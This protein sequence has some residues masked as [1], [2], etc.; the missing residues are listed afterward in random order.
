MKKQ[1][2]DLLVT[3]PESLYLLLTAPSSR[4]LLRGVRT[5]IVDEVH[6]LARDKRGSHLSLSLE[7]LDA[8]VTES[9]GRVQRIG[10]S[11][12]QR[13]LELVARLLTRRP[14]RAP[15][16]HDRRLRP[17]PRS[18]RGDRAALD[19]ARG[20][21]ERRSDVRHPRP[22]RRAHPA[23]PHDADL[24]QHPEDGRAGRPPVDRAPRRRRTAGAG[25]ATSTPRCSW[26]RTTAAFRRPAGASSRP[27]CA[28]VT[29]A[30]SSP[31][32]RSNWASTSARSSWSARSGRPGPSAPSSSASAGP[33]TTARARRPAGST[34]RPATSWSSAPRCWPP[35]ARGGSTCSS[36]RWPRS[37]CSPSR[38]W[39]RWPPPTSATSRPS[40]TSSAGPRRTPS[41]HGRTSTTW[42]PWPAGASRPAG[43]GAVPTCTTTPSTAACGPAGAPGWPR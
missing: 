11:A 24:R 37:T 7:R 33:T 43:A 13:P 4:A 17:R 32:P 28:P 41:C 9:G 21:H 10:L 12:T 14:P 6:T 23:P 1:A 16:D 30:R 26:P 2:P 5:V 31:P 3:T 36:R 42:S 25:A 22:H 38:S 27:G 18:R 40:G 29:C 19:R 15:A 34:R 20:G 8:L 35:C 39:P